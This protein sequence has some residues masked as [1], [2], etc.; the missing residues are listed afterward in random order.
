VAT[1]TR[2]RALSAFF[3]ERVIQIEAVQRY[4]S[5]VTDEGMEGFFSEGRLPWSFG[6][7]LWCLDG[8]TLPLLYWTPLSLPM[9]HALN[10]AI[11]AFTEF[12]AALRNGEL[13]A[14]GAPPNGLR[15]DLDRAEWTPTDLDLI[16]D[17][18]KGELIE[19]PMFYPDRVRWSD[20]TLRETESVGAAEQVRAAE[21]LRTAAP[22]RKL[23][24][25]DWDDFWNHEQARKQQGLLPNKKAY[26]AEAEQLIK[27]RYGVTVPP[28]ELRRIK[29]ALYRG[30]FQ[31]PKRQTRKKPK[32][33]L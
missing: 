17:V 3:L 30:D 16:L 7:F 33:K 8:P 32:H 21:P 31:R 11:A 5:A 10:A 19:A 12:I 14:R 13:I 18:R 28:T 27:E 4:R 24:G 20:I 2:W 22:E 23:G 1:R 15:C 26:L 9:Q 25:I 29:A 6:E